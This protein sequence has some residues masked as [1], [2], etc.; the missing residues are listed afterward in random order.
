[1]S[2][3]DKSEIW[4][5]QYR[6]EKAARKEA[7]DLLESKSRELYQANLQLKDLTQEL[8]QRVRDRTKVIEAQRNSAIEQSRQLL[9]SQQRFEDVIEAAGEYVWETDAQLNV[10]YLSVPASAAFGY[11]IDELLGLP[12]AALFNP[13]EHDSIE[14]FVELLRGRKPF[15]G[16]IVRSRHKNGSFTW[17]SISG[18]PKHEGEGRFAGFRGTGLDVTEIQRAKEAAVKAHRSKSIF[19]SNMSH[20]IRTPLNGIIGMS[21]VLIDTTTDK[22]QLDQARSIKSS[23]DAL[24]FLT[25]KLFDISA[26]E[27][28]Q[29][30]LEEQDYSINELVD[31]TLEFL[32]TEASRKNL[33]VL[34]SISSDLPQYAIGDETRIRQALTNLCD[35]AVK[36]TESGQI[37]LNIHLEASETEYIVFEISDT[38]IGIPKTELKHIFSSFEGAHE[39]SYGREG[40]TGLGLAI[41]RG[42][43]ECMGGSLLASSEDRKGS[44]FTFR[45][46]ITHS[47]KQ[48]K[49]FDN[50]FCIVVGNV[51]PTTSTLFNLLHRYGVEAIRLNKSDYRTIGEKLE[52]PKETDSILLKVQPSE[53]QQELE[54]DTKLIERGFRK[55]EV[56][57]QGSSCANTKT[58]TSPLRHHQLLSILQNT[59]SETNTAN[60]TIRADFLK[61]KTCLI[62]DD[63]KTN[64][65][66]AK[67]M[68]QQFSVK[69]DIALSGQ[70]GID[71]VQENEY[72]FILMDL[73]MPGLSG[74]ETSKKIRKLGI[75]CPI[76]AVTA[77]TA[78]GELESLK[79]S[80]IDSL[81]HKPL[82]NWKLRNELQHFFDPQQAPKQGPALNSEPRIIFD[83]EEL[84][85]LFS[86]NTAL[87]KTVIREFLK[88]TENLFLNFK[89]LLSE[90]SR[91]EQLDCLHN[92]SGASNSLRA[93]EF[94]TVCSDL[95]SA[96]R[97]RRDPNQLFQEAQQAYTRL[98]SRLNQVLNS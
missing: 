93:K 7:E 31:D 95:Q 37:E 97:D 28:G 29:L 59:K 9:Y 20:E 82:F 76:I 49:R 11:D 40:G 42:I 21:Q 26:I 17:Q 23:A 74:I 47:N 24:Y 79:E 38:G 88:Q 4:E 32:N 71:L 69:S 84:L 13:E 36:F 48:P 52:H 44:V 22:L 58:L 92:L 66:V 96:I 94:A 50:T 64:L 43:A 27:S 90:G 35:N 61:N 86:Q 60:N 54:M 62:V 87:V 25:N 65:Q 78:E 68:L 3:E 63:N 89:Q 33:D 73:R 34:L 8:E 45:I 53:D 81:V 12:I 80:G 85:S 57:P 46:P 15:K 5:R 16:H 67:A 55:Y 56:K 51:E 10:T 72:D 18:L 39:L 41:S 30:R 14:F 75:R 70:A 98:N 19:L 83:E 91:Q 77:N 6:R 2:S 1:M